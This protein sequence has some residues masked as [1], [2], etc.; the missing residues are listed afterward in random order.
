MIRFI[1][2][3]LNPCA[4]CGELGE[5]RRSH[6][7]P[8]S[9][10]KG[11]YDKFHRYRHISLARPQIKSFEQKGIRERL[12]C[13]SCEQKISVWEQYGKDFVSGY[14]C[15]V[16]GKS[17][18]H[19]IRCRGVDY[20]RLKLFAMS[21]L[22]RS[23]VARHPFFKKVSLGIREHTLRTHLLREDPGA[24]N[25]FP[26]MVFGLVF[27]GGPMTGAI[28]QPQRFRIEGALAYRFIFGGVMWAIV[29]SR[30]GLPSSLSEFTVSPSGHLWTMVCNA[31]ELEDLT[32]IA[33]ALG[34]SRAEVTLDFSIPLKA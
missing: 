5:L 18:G 3:K 16:S 31:L 25:D 14:V 23:S 24:Q 8:E 34:K 17:D 10:Y 22:W 2:K 33:K 19:L 29:A 15:R 13:D 30:S 12:L 21:V 1:Q 9:M 6:I 28:L 7:V 20:K 26:I 32:A 27:R 4:L 11:V